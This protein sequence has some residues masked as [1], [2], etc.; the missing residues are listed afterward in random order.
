MEPCMPKRIEP[1][2]DADGRQ[3]ELNPPSGGSWLRDADGGLTPADAAT[4]SG[5]G[6]DW[7][8]DP[9]PQDPSADPLATP[10]AD[11]PPISTR[12]AGKAAAA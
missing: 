3:V 10:A 9:A 11:A 6:L 7:G 8:A 5:A 2:L 12:K 1:Q 4:A